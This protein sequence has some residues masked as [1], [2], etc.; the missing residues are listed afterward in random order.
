MKN[1]KLSPKKPGAKEPTVKPRKARV[2]PAQKKPVFEEFTNGWG[3]RGRKRW[4]NDAS[5]NAQK[6]K[7]GK[8]LHPLLAP[9]I[10]NVQSDFKCSAF[11]YRS[12]RHRS[13]E[14]A[15]SNAAIKHLREHHAKQRRGET[16]TPDE[17][18]H[19]KVW[20]QMTNNARRCAFRLGQIMVAAAACGD[21]RFFEHVFVIVQTLKSAATSTGSAEAQ[22]IEKAYDEIVFVRECK[23]MGINPSGGLSAKFAHLR[24][25]A[26]A[27]K[28]RQPIKIKFPTN[29][30]VLKQIERHPEYWGLDAEDKTRWS[31]TDALS[32]ANRLKQIERCCAKA[33]KALSSSRPAR[34]MP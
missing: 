26:F 21:V 20:L 2:D 15:A 11:P 14:A 9:L 4:D 23:K 32:F 7:H 5:W 33:G 22:V 3:L 17:Q 28:E 27:R 13:C 24:K 29:V 31:A 6:I 1:E 16:L 19:L 18:V 8:L 25:L 30:E 10:F 12:A 34:K